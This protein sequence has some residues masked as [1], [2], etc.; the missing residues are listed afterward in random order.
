VG[1]ASLPGAGRRGVA[2]D[3]SVYVSHPITAVASM[4]YMFAGFKVRPPL[5]PFRTDLIAATASSGWCMHH[6]KNDRDEHSGIGHKISVSI[7]RLEPSLEMPTTSGA[8]IV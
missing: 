2:C 6:D 3:P 1:L 4:I 7:N 8:R 5:R